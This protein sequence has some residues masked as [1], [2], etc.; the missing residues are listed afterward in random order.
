MN[1]NLIS[2]LP[3]YIAINLLSKNCNAQQH[4]NFLKGYIITAKS[5]TV[6]GWVLFKDHFFNSKKCVFKP[7]IDGPS[8]TYSSNQLIAYSIADKKYF[9][10]T[11]IPNG[12]LT[13][14]EKVFLEYVIQG[15]VSL[16]F[17]QDRYFIK[18]ND[19][20]QELTTVE[21]ET[22]DGTKVYI[23]RQPL[24]KLTLRKEMTDCLTIDQYLVKTT[25][26]LKSLSQLLV[27]YHKC[28]GRSF[29]KYGGDHEKI[30]IL[31][32]LAPGVQATNLKFQSEYSS[33]YLFA[34]QYK[35][36]WNLSF[37]ASMWLE[38]Y[39]KETFNR[40]RFKSGLTFYTNKFRIYEENPGAGL[41]H[42]LDIES[43]RIEVPII[44]KCYLSRNNTFYLQGGIGLNRNIKW[45][46]HLIVIVPPS[47][48]Y[49]ESSD[50]KPNNLSVNILAGGG[51]DFSLG[52][53]RFVTEISYGLNPL[54]LQGKSNSPSVS[55]NSFALNVGVS[56]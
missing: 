15:E 54:I 42:Q 24:Y 11:E 1:K 55:I 19:G 44:L 28:T 25:F 47:Y 35:T 51:L 40:I 43:T 27:D 13:S 39:R 7:S 32:S 4:E 3:L 37:T 36:D 10:S 53:R 30:S 6:T 18:T 33:E 23:K 21:K 38:F 34:D 45:K 48:I 20:I 22:N 50:L 31:F 52:N 41:N 12:D 29:I 8:E 5:D 49:R 17:Y 2:L 46:D 26:N 14:R 16:L 9:Y 56:F